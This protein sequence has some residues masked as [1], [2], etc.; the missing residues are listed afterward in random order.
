MLTL[1]VN[2]KYECAICHRP[3]G[4]VRGLSIHVGKHHKMDA[5]AY[6]DQY[7]KL[8]DEGKC[9]GNVCPAILEEKFDRKKCSARLDE[10][11]GK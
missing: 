7:V 10:F 1:N 4:D 6:Y 3:Y 2:N 9:I 5:K 11:F 8:A